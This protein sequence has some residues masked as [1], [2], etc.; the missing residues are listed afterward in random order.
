MNA[1]Q[2]SGEVSDAIASGVGVVA[3]ESTIISHGLPTASAA[4]TAREIEGAVRREGAVPATVAIVDGVV[5]VGL[6]D[7][8]LVRI[9]EDEGVV[10]VSVRDLAPVTGKRLTG[11]T[12]VAATS[13]LAHSAGIGLFATGGLGGVHRGARETWDVSADLG[14]LASLPITVVCAGVKSILDV[15]ATLERLESLSV[16]VLGYGT[17]TFPGFYVRDTGLPVPWRVDSPAEVAAVI[18]QRGLL[19]LDRGIVVA[20]PI[21]EADEMDPDLHERTLV[22]GLAAVREHGVRGKDVTPFLLGYFHEHTEGASLAAN[23]ALVLS[24][25]ALAA[26]IAVQKE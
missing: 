25:A 26:R 24:N 19:G 11:A 15:P 7:D 9:A 5:R 8:A 21:A 13:Y 20:N 17:D 6:S 10:K 1:I 3:L 22:S 2:I 16:S 12:T 18:G 4:A 14:A 23:V